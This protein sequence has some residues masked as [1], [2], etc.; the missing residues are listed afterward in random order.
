[1]SSDIV[2]CRTG[3]IHT[4]ADELLI[5]SNRKVDASKLICQGLLVSKAGALKALMINGMNVIVVTVF[6]M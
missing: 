3:T 1:M 4:Y 6:M 2:N 5:A